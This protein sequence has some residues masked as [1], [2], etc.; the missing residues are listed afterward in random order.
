MKLP[1][2]VVTVAFGYCKLAIADADNRI[3]CHVMDVEG[4]KEV[5]EEFVRLTNRP[6]VGDDGGLKLDGR[7]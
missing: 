2:R 6:R 4:A 7:K 5:A 1:L 3:I